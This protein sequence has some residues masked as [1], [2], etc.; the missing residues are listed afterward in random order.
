[1]VLTRYAHARMRQGVQRVEAAL[2]RL[3]DSLMPAHDHIFQFQVPLTDASNALQ[4]DHIVRENIDHIIADGK[5][6]NLRFVS[7]GIENGPWAEPPEESVSVTCRVFCVRDGCV[8]PVD[9]ATLDS[10]GRYFCPVCDART[11][12]ARSKL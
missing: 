12:A 2:G 8:V 3:D 4:I 9:T 5:E 11:G 1:M 10:T 7:S 6:K